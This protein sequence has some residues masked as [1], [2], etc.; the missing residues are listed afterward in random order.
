MKELILI[1][2][3]MAPSIEKQLQEKGLPVPHNIAIFEESA[4][5]ITLLY[6]RA[7]LTE[8]EARQAKQRLVD[9]LGHAIAE[10][11]DED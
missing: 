4:F 9:Q 7:I 3:A 6:L 2:G 8:A 10:T 5:S 11:E 1:M